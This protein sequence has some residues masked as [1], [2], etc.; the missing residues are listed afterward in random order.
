MLS[1]ETPIALS[2]ETPMASRFLRVLRVT[3]ALFLLLILV[4][5][6]VAAMFI[7]GDVDLLIVHNVVGGAIAITGLAQLVVAVMH[8]RALRRDGHRHGFWLLI[9]AALVFATTVSQIVLGV[10]RLVAPH[11]F[12]ALTLTAL[13]AVMFVLVFTDALAGNTA[14]S[15]PAVST[16]GEAR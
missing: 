1:A 4:Q 7:S 13:A 3:A 9:L 6:L 10:I 2:A 16:E 8:H 12:I 14:T 5:G 15:S 11:I